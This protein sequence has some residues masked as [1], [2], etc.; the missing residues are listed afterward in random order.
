MSYRQGLK[1]LKQLRG[2]TCG[3]FVVWAKRERGEIRGAI[4]VMD[5]FSRQ[6]VG[7]R[8]M[9]LGNFGAADVHTRMQVHTQLS[10]MRR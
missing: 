6:L 1:T 8:R 4:R 9:L 2:E 5:D 10:V 3:I 7:P